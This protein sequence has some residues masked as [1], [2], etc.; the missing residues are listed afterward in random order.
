MCLWLRVVGGEGGRSGESCGVRVCG[1]CCWLGVG[2][3]G[4]RLLVG[5]LLVWV[6][7]GVR[8][9]RVECSGLLVWVEGRIRVECSRLLIWVQDGLMLVECALLLVWV[10]RNWSKWHTSLPPAMRLDASYDE[11]CDE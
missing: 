4:A 8:L 10:V 11:E 7:G 2:D 6:E 9:V 1:E 3:E 5:L